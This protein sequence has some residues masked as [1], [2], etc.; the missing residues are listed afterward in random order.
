[1][2]VGGVQWSRGSPPGRQET[3]SG[4]TAARES[5]GLGE[6][7]Q[8]K[9]RPPYRAEAHPNSFDPARLTPP[10]TFPA[11]LSRA[12][13]PR[14]GVGRP[15]TG[16]PQQLDGGLHPTGGPR[17]EDWRARSSQGPRSV[18]SGFPGPAP[19]CRL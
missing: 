6:T 16:P 5:K 19:G 14:R 3:S 13:G 9:V 17:D 1:M 12:E 10:R 11:S 8:R 18:S 15:G 7:R 2:C 4:P